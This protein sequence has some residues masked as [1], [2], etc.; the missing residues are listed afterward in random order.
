M[1]IG[2]SDT[3]RTQRKSVSMFWLVAAGL[4]L[5]VIRDDSFHP[6]YPRSNFS[7][8]RAEYY[9]F[10]SIQYTKSTKHH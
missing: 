3:R 10:G 2:S 6:L 1:A 7:L 5:H 8:P 9:R 4:N